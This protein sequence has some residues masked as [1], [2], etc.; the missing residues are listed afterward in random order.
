MAAFSATYGRGQK[1]N[2]ASIFGDYEFLD[3]TQVSVD[4]ENPETQF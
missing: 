1:E 4:S 3:A 2:I